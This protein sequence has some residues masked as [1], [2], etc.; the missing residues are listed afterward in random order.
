VII[1]HAR[2]VSLSLLL[3]YP[4]VFAFLFHRAFT[5]CI[6]LLYS[7]P[8]RSSLRT[9][10]APVSRSLLSRDQRAVINPFIDVAPLKSVDHMLRPCLSS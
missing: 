3:L 8:A 2:A 1:A 9:T 10:S 6:L 4:Q 5:L 7:T